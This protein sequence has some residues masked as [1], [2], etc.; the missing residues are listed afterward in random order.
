M[1]VH[2][3][4][5]GIRKRDRMTL[6]N[7]VTVIVFWG[8]IV[9]GLLITLFL[10]NE[11][12]H[13]GLL[14]R[15]RE[16]DAL[17]FEWQ[18]LVLAYD[19]GEA[20]ERFRERH[21][22][23]GGE[24]IL[25]LYR[26]GRELL[27]LPP[28]RAS[29]AYPEHQVRVIQVRETGGKGTYRM[30][31]DYPALA[32]TVHDER[33]R[34]L[35]SLG[36]LL[37]LI[38]LLLRFVLD[39]VLTRPILTMV[40]TARRI[41]EGDSWLR[42][43]TSRDDE[44]GELA[45][46]MNEAVSR[47][48]KAQEEAQNALEL[49][50]VTLHSI[51]DGVITTDDRGRIRFVNPVAE[52]LLGRPARALQGLY[53]CDVLHLVNEDTGER[54]TPPVE[55]SL[56]EGRVCEGETHCSLIP[57]DGR[58]ISV[59][60]SIAPIRVRG[61]RVR[62]AVM[63]MHDISEARALQEE[64]SFQASHDPLTGLYNR[65]EFDLELQRCLDRARRDGQVHTLCY[66]DLDQFKVINDTCG[67]TAGDEF[68]QG[69]SAQLVQHVR[70]SDFLARLGGDEFAIILQ[71]CPMAQA[72]KVAQGL[73][74]AI[75]DYRFHW[76]G[77]VFQA[78]ASIGLA[79]I[80]GVGT[81]QEVLA[82]ADM[83]CYAAKEAGRNRYH[84]YRSNDEQ[85][86]RR[87]SEMAM[88]SRIRDALEQRRLVLFCQ[89]IVPTE[90][91]DR[92]DRYEILVRMRDEDGEL[93]PPGCFLPAAERYQ[94]MPEIDLW[95]MEEAIRRLAEVHRRAPEVA[96]SINLSGQSLDLEGLADRVRA[97]IER[98]GVAPGAITFEITE[99][100]AINN[101]GKA[102]RFI[103]EIRELGCRFA[104]DDF[105]T[106][107]SSY[108]YLK[109]LEVDYLKIDG[110]FVRHIDQDPVDQALVR[111]VNEVAHVLGMRTIAEFV[112]TEAA[113]IALRALGVDYLQGYY[114]GRPQ[115]L[116]AV[117]A[118]ADGPILRLVEGER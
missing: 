47:L 90:C 22:R 97:C 53:L 98:H 86:Q 87:R 48:R 114:I 25:H 66:I 100:A 43:D 31:V 69:L 34:L 106:G 19:P 71:F 9:V 84:V 107:V 78:S 118:T 30:V 24:R 102:R 50:Q 6:S 81:A 23:D 77:K 110:S 88:L 96:F 10:V 20:L 13:A 82:A 7:K 72:E 89:P 28:Q 44:F 4:Q 80:E 85:L 68:L 94:I 12:Q 59:V 111:S 52:N 101:L 32:E 14:E 39:R 35:L 1:A 112:E 29:R 113:R 55:A 65:R 75:Q 27:R 76:Q 91:P 21:R 57:G 79:P 33:V 45:S 93:V 83:A 56:R 95:V 62:G 38:G 60:Y 116:D 17:A 115:P 70:R 74:A 11:Q 18:R 42:F 103:T 109:G 54:I 58:R 16:A 105:G 37:L 117:F 73:L 49:A 40:D 104:L 51:A 41:S 8:L 61:N 3:S 26:D 36:A 15:Q 2:M 64:L 92:H 108:A 67:H 99:T 63:V 46:F 5:R